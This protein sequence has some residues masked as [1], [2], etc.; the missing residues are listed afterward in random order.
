MGNVI[1]DWRLG[2]RIGGWDR[3]SGIV[4]GDWNCGLR[5]GIHYLEIG[6]CD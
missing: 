5:I 6:D 2:I 1:W 3:G 4:I